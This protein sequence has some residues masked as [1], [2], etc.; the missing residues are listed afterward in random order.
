MAGHTVEHSAVAGG[1]AGPGGGACP[2][3]LLPLEAVP[4]LLVGS[5]GA[6]VYV[7]PNIPVRAAKLE[8]KFPE[9]VV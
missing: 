4:G 3:T 1:G 9:S 5:T 8:T 6:P 2:L 7:P